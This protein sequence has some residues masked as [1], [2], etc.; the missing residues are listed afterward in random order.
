MSMP[1]LRNYVIGALLAFFFGGYVIH[2]LTAPTPAPA[3]TFSTLSGEKM[4]LTE[5]KGKIVLVNFWA[6]TCGYCVYEMPNLVETY[7]RFRDKGFEVVAVAMPD[8]SADDV[9]GYTRKHGLPFPVAL[10][11]M[12]EANQAFGRVQATPTSFLIDKSGNIVE[13]RRGG[14]DFDQLNAYLK[15]QLG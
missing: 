9:I 5:Q 2:V 3:V 4:N 8:D 7:N 15:Q 13:N 1:K 6:T 11:A 10:D 12:G 14:P